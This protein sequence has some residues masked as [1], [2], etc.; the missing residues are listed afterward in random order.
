M[1]LPNAIFLFFHSYSYFE[2]GHLRNFGGC[3]PGCEVA[4][5]VGWLCSL[6][7]WLFGWL[8]ACEGFHISGGETHIVHQFCPCLYG[9]T[10]FHLIL[11]SL[12]H[13]RRS[14]PRWPNHHFAW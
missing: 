7:S 6:L 11:S 14:T 5:L 1:F 3:L 12:F 13:G 10:M 8:I 9:F 4:L 2:V